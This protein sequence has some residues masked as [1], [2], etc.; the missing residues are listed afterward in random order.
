MLNGVNVMF[1]KKISLFL[2]V[3]VFILSLSAV[4]SADNN[5]TDDV[6]TSD[7]DEEPPSGVVELASAN[8]T[9]ATSNDN[10][11]YD[12]SSD[13][14]KMYY[15]GKAKYEAVLSQDDKPVVN[16]HVL[17]K[18][19]GKTYNK[20]TDNNGKIAIDLNL[21]VGKYTVSAVFGNIV[22]KSKINVLPV[23][24][25]KNV[26]KTYK[27]SK[28]Y[29][30]TFLNSQGKPLKNTEVKFKIN[31]KTYTEKTNSKG[32]AKLDLNLKVGNYVV[33]AI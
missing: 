9:L 26:V 5:S 7:V 12:L 20:T 21:K 14:V 29:S 33:Y 13:D 19:D 8:D 10:D 16:E 3:L 31:G 18:L 11:D 17:I 32:I 2:I 30:A 23:V 15:K 24:S 6:V 1:N 28:Q 27:S 4:V 22:S 25:G